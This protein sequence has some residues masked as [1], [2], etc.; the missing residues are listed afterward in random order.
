MNTALANDDI[1][2]IAVDYYES[3]QALNAAMLEGNIDLDCQNSWHQRHCDA[4]HRLKAFK[5]SGSD[6]ATQISTC[7]I[8]EGFEA[9]D[10]KR[11]VTVS[12]TTD[13]SD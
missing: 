11:R 7:Y 12:W 8:R 5:V 2:G 9:D 10:G 13:S 1:E 4:Y 6:F 3:P